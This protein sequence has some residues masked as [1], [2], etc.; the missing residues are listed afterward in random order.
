LRHE[1]IYTVPEDVFNMVR[2]LS[3]R[4]G[5]EEEKEHEREMGDFFSLAPLPPDDDTNFHFNGQHFRL[6]ED[7]GV[8]SIP[9]RGDVAD[10]LRWVREARR[11]AD[12]VLM[13]VHS[14]EYGN[15]EIGKGLEDAPDFLEAFAHECIDEGVDV[16]IGHGPRFIRGI[17]LY[18]SKPIFYGLGTFG[19]E[20]QTYPKLPTD[21]YVRFGLGHTNTPADVYDAKAQVDDPEFQV[22]IIYWQGL[23]PEVV[24][25][26]RALDALTLH[27]VDQQRDQPRSRHGRPM[28][29][30]ESTATQALER[31]A[32]LSERYGTR[33]DINR[34]AAD[35]AIVPEVVRA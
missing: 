13:S 31:I 2:L 19:Y 4:L 8:T 26:G 1:K 35:V 25:K 21:S 6:G 23:L 32:K 24:F 22:D 11:Q 30:R 28:L 17:E 16:F 3:E 7:F 27:I 10:I 33:I 18:N 5:A 9:D 20:N 34:G 29:S 12:W 15:G 14:H